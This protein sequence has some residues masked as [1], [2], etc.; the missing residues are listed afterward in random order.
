LAAAGSSLYV[1]AVGGFAAL[2]I[3][4][5]KVRWRLRRFGDVALTVQ[6]LTVQGGVLYVGGSALAAY[7]R[8]TG[9]R[10]AWNPKP[11]DSVLAL[12]ATRSNVYLGGSFGGFGGV[13]RHGLAALD[14]TTGEPTAWNPALPRPEP[15]FSGPVNALA[16]Q[17]ETLYV[18]GGF[19][20]VG[21]KTRHNLAAFDLTNGA[22][23]DWNPDAGDEVNTL[24]VSATTVYA[25]GDFKEVGGKPHVGVAAIDAETGV[26]RPWDA[27]TCCSAAGVLSLT[28]SGSTLFL[29][30]VLDT[31]NGRVRHGIAA[32][33]ATTGALLPWNPGAN[34]PVW[35]L[36]ASGKTLYA[37]GVFTTIGGKNRRGLA[38][39]DTASGAVSAW[40]PYVTGGAVAA[41]AL[42][43]ST[44]YVGGDFDHVSG[45]SREGLAAVSEGTIY[46]GGSFSGAAGTVQSNFAVFSEP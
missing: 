45:L 34:S 28:L 36:L 8:R 31:V 29:G 27:N 18:G 32:V 12:A 23:T 24:A 13:E 16:A 25:G 5:G 43:E 2:D 42:S 40:N 14:A 37:G 30:G 4:T 6:A 22:L 19:D 11:N 15:A 44:L 46:V 7:D 33:D 39:L 20:R 21:S 17:G 35:A 1:G 26:V 3:R 9:K 38:A 10:L 41:L